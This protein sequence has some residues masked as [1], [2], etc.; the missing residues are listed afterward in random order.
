MQGSKVKLIKE[1]GL[2]QPLLL[3]RALSCLVA[4][5][6]PKERLL[7]PTTLPAPFFFPLNFFDFVTLWHL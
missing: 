6:P 2:P 1:L 3:M 4:R 7:D 5:S